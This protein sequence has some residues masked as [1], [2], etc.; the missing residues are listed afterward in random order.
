MN[1]YRFARLG[2]WLLPLALA[3]AGSACVM[4]SE[5]S[6]QATG[7]ATV[8]L[9]QTPSDVNCLRLRV[10]GRFYVERYFDVVPGQDTILTLSKLPIGDDTFT[11]HAYAESCGDVVASSEPTWRSDP[12]TV[13]LTA[14]HVAK[15]S[16]LM[17]RSSGNA[18]VSID[19]ED[20]DANLP[21]DG[22][23][24][25]SGAQDGGPAED[26]GVCS[27][28]ETLCME[29]N[30]TVKTCGADHQ[31]DFYE[32]P[33]SCYLGLCQCLDGDATCSNDDVPLRC[34]GGQWQPQGP[35]CDGTCYSDHFDVACGCDPGTMACNG[36]I[37]QVC[38]PEWDFAQTRGL[39]DLGKCSGSCSAGGQCQ[40][41]SCWEW[42]S[43]RRQNGSIET[44][45]GEWIET[46]S[47]DAQPCM[48]LGDGIPARE[49]CKNG[50][51]QRCQADGSWLNIRFGYGCPVPTP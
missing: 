1:T 50:F 23:T 18:E 4:S 37:V 29:I 36:S 41:Q 47:Y 44:C 49:R 26:A 33:T 35:R 19:F 2:Q 12:V 22:G 45:F 25:D 27:P 34:R 30:N 6:D 14:G 16:L 13:T 40:P 20:Y 17:Y 10:E 5:I 51:R 11:G 7:V 43:T 38:E 46:G 8:T 9:K 24:Q 39:R 28:G 3:L 32:C 21:E 15:V 31:W 42:G 48:L